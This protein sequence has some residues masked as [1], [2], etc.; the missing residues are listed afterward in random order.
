MAQPTAYNPAH[1]FLTDEG[2]NP[3]FPGSEIDIELNALATTTD[4]ILANL[5]LV[6]RDDGAL[7]NGVVTYDS[8]S[9]SLQTNG[10]APATT[11]TTATLYIAGDAV[12]Q[13]GSLYRALVS[14]TSGT[15]ATDLAAANWELIAA[16]PTGPTG[17]AATIAVGT[18]TGLSPGATPTVVN[19][20]TSGAATLNFGI[21][22]GATGSTGSAA[23]VAVGTVTTLSAGA[24]ATVTNVGTSSA[25][26]LNFGIPQGIAGT[27]G[28]SG[29]PTVGQIPV[30]TNA[31]T[32]KGVTIS[33]LVKGNGASDPTAAVAGTDYLAPAAIGVSVQAYDADLAAIAALTSAANKGFMFSGPGTATTYDLTSAGLALLD[34][35]NAAAQRATLSAAGFTQTDFISGI[36]KTGANSDFRIVEKLPFAATITEITAK[37]S[38]GTITLTWKINTT[39]ITTGVNSVT[40]TQSSVTPSAA[41]VAA[42][43]D[44][45]V[46]T[47][48]SNSS[49]VDISFTV[50]FTK[51]LVA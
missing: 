29:T 12:I 18:V 33:G 39:A 4:Q 47:G 27:L 26:T 46:A 43:N 15:F 13:N 16:L 14:H 6:Q 28:A 38:S 49:A 34:D 21:P 35:A 5:A 40:S 36:I 25:A 32:Q 1:E 41:N 45:L 37:S 24:S 44:A 31:T 17:A 50:K 51:T 22:A 8:L 42:A 19:V 48:S 20:G 23:T 11:W 2:A 10:L 7:K 3:N 30:W 9:A